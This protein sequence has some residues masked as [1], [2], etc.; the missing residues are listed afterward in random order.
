MSVRVCV[1]TRAL[2]VINIDK[3]QTFCLPAKFQAL[4]IHIQERLAQRYIAKLYLVART[5][6]Y[7]AKN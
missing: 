7:I 5:C 4:E 2:K 1:C 3:F 6:M